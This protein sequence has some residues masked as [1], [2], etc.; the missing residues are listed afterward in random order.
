MSDFHPSHLRVIYD[1]YDNKI[2]DLYLNGAL[3]TKKPNVIR[4]VN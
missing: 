3:L 1:Q 2:V 4:L